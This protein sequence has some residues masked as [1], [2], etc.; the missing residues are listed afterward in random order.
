M[1]SLKFKAWDKKEGRFRDDVFI[2]P[3][4]TPFIIRSSDGLN[5]AINK[6]YKAKGDILGGDYA[7]IDFTDWYA[8]ENIEIQ[9]T[10]SL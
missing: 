1:E 2:S 5:K 10:I 8:I 4:G 9:W 6:Y 7:E 3:K